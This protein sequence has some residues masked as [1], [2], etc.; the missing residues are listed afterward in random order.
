MVCCGYENICFPSEKEK[1]VLW[2]LPL[3]WSYEDISSFR[4]PVLFL[5]FFFYLLLYR[6]PP[7]LKK[8]IKL[9]RS[10]A[11]SQLVAEF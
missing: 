10:A 6:F 1:I 11:A 4:G 3:N 2:I 8:K 5:Q 7:H 9:A